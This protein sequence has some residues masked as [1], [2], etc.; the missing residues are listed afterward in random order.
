MT[1]MVTPHAAQQQQWW[2]HMWGNDGDHDAIYGTT[3]AMV[4]P[5]T[6]QRQW[7]WHNMWCNDGDGDI[8]RCTMTVTV[9]PNVAQRQ[10]LRHYT[11]WDW[12]GCRVTRYCWKDWRGCRT[13][14]SRY[15]VCPGRPRYRM[16]CWV[17]RMTGRIWKNP[18]LTG[19]SEPRD[20]SDP[21][22]LDGIGACYLTDVVTS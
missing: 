15:I 6:V 4:T 8:T 3:T 13:T 22:S 17:T 12:R 2:H 11:R 14:S 20:T 19:M 18:I 10:Q 5:Y 21:S 7:W 1:V 16:Y 9:T